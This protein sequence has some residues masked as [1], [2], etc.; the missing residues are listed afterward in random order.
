M[1]NYGARYS[2]VQLCGSF[3]NW[4]TKHNMMFDPHSNQW[5]VTMHLKKGKYFYKYVLNGTTWVENEKES[6]EKDAKGNTN[7]VVT[8]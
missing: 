8:I 4:Q 1:H 2:S 3:D 5:F 7:N 6:K